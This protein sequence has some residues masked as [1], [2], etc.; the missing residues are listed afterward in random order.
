MKWIKVE[1]ELPP[2]DEEVLLLVEGHFSYSF[3]D[4][5]KTRKIFHGSFNRRFGW[6]KPFIP[7]IPTAVI[8]WIHKPDD[9]ID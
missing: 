5:C 1:L 8:A 6:H 4:S 9:L 3:G 2:D 7:P